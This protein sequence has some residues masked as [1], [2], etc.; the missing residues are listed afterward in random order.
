M[1][2]L[3]RH[4]RRGN[5]CKVSECVIVMRLTTRTFSFRFMVRSDWSVGGW[6]KGVGLKLYDVTH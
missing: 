6:A 5:L 3:L 4:K 2:Q 1:E